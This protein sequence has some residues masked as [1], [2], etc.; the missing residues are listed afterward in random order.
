M[1]TRTEKKDLPGDMA[2]E[3]LHLE[4]DVVAYPQAS[5]VRE[6]SRSKVAAYARR[7]LYADVLMLSVTTLVLSVMA[8]T[9]SFSG[10]IP[11]TPAAW[12]LGMS[13]AVLAVFYLRGMYLPP[14]RLELIEVLRTVVAGTAVAVTVAMAVRVTLVDDE[15]VAAETVR[16]WLLALPLLAGGRCALL[17]HEARARRDG[18]ASRRTLIVGGG[19]VG[20]LTAE[21][22][23]KDPELGLRPVA[24]LDDDPLDAD[25]APGGLPTLSAHG[26]FE[27]LVGQLRID[28]VIIA[29][30][31][32][33]HDELLSL[34]RD[35]WR[36][37]ITVSVVP[38]LFEIQGQRVFTEHLGGLPLMEMRASNPRGWQFR[39]KYALDRVVAAL[40]LAVLAPFLLAI[41]AAVLVGMGRPVLYRQRR[42]GRDGHVFDMLKFRTMRPN[43]AGEADADWAEAQL[44]G[45]IPL[46]HTPLED[47]LTPVGKFLRRTSLDELPQLWNVLRGDMSL[48]GPRPERATYVEQFEKGLYRYGERHRVKSGLTGWAQVH[49]LRGKTSL[50]DRT[51]WD[52]HY[53]ENWS[54]WLD[55]K[56][57]LMTVA[58]LGRAHSE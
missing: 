48:I 57:V 56:I 15:W 45:E 51:E 11:A 35:C 50:S 30:S 1:L 47:R 13:G 38:R 53:I 16:F 8:S 2:T 32:A 27:A 24:F 52:N 36:L 26:D 55:L 46:V 49:G 44:G 9:T 25:S 7:A 37:G 5:P 31:R 54:L 33:S 6:R 19:R 43:A 20:T 29:F 12:L 21:R 41:M 17:W 4:P 39:L 3:T 22:L 10:N 28:H 42:V 40:A 58:T 23:L 34:A 14:L 18:D